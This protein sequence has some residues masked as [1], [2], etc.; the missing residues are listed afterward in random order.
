LQDVADRASV[1]CAEC[2]WRGCVVRDT[3]DERNLC[4]LASGAGTGCEPRLTGSPGG[5][6]LSP[7]NGI[8]RGVPATRR[9]RRE[10]ASPGRKRERQEGLKC[11]N[12]SATRRVG[13]SLLPSERDY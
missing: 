6:Q 7:G 4:H 2:K 11:C 5:P 3:S 13:A 8:V 10:C 9:A 12:T 1:I